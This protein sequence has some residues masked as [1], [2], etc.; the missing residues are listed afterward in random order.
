MMTKLSQLDR[1]TLGCL[2][3]VAVVVIV[4]FARLGW[5]FGDLFLIWLGFS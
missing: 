5:F 2:T 1:D 4:F 3:P